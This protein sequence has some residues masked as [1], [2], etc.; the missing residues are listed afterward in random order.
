MRWSFGV[1]G[2][3]FDAAES[4]WQTPEKAPRQRYVQS[5]ADRIAEAIDVMVRV[6]FMF[7]WIL[8]GFGPAWQDHA[9]VLFHAGRGKRDGVV[10]V[11]RE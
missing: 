7:Q 9:K 1:A 5:A 2:V 11:E 6:P 4:L 8:I 10:A 3:P